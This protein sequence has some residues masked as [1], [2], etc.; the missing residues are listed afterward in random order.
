GG[1]VEAD[2][3]VQLV[4]RQPL[5][6]QPTKP[7]LFGGPDGGC[8]SGGAVRCP[9]LDLREDDHGVAGGDEVELARRRPPIPVDDVVAVGA[10]GARPPAPP[11]PPPVPSCAAQRGT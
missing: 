11:P 8:R 7:P 10:G 9:C 1:D 2:R 6:R 4:G 3:A 5:H